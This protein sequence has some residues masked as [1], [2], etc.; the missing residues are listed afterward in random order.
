MLVVYNNY[1]VQLQTYDFA[2][3]RDKISK[4]YA[5]KESLALPIHS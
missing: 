3:R 1:L 4:R 5:Q 2:M